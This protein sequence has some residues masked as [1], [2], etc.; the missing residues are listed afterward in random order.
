MDNL[1]VNN[2]KKMIAEWKQSQVCTVYSLR[3]CHLCKKKNTYTQS[4]TKKKP[5]IK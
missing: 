1:I 4:M 5:I 2:T 3:K